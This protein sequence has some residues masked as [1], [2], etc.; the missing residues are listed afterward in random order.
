M[1]SMEKT[2][3]AEDGGPAAADGSMTKA[4]KG[5][6]GLV[7]RL[8][9]VELAGQ[10]EVFI[11]SKAAKQ[12]RENE[13]AMK[14]A[15]QAEA[16]AEEAAAKGASA[17]ALEERAARERAALVEEVAKKEDEKRSVQQQLR[18][19]R[20][21]LLE[22]RESEEKM[23]LVAVSKGRDTQRMKQEV[24]CAHA[25]VA[26]LNEELTAAYAANHS[27]LLDHVRAQLVAAQKE[28]EEAA[29]SH[30]S[31]S[32]LAAERERV[33]EQR[34]SALESELAESRDHSAAAAAKLDAKAAVEQQSEELRSKLAHATEAL[35]TMVHTKQSTMSMKEVELATQ[36]QSAALNER[37]LLKTIRQQKLAAKGLGCIYSL[38]LALLRRRLREL[39]AQADDSAKKLVKFAD[40]STADS[41]AVENERLQTELETS[42]A[43]IAPLHQK[44]VNERS[45]RRKS[46]MA[47]EAAESQIPKL[48]HE[49]DAVCAERAALREHNTFLSTSLTRLQLDVARYEKGAVG[50]AQSVAKHEAE[51]AR[52]DVEKRALQSQ[53]QALGGRLKEQ[54]RALGMLIPPRDESPPPKSTPRKESPRKVTRWGSPLGQPTYSVGGKL[55]PLVGSPTPSPRDLPLTIMAQ[56]SAAPISC[57]A[58][59]LRATAN[60]RLT[61]LALRQK[62]REAAAAAAA[63]SA[64]LAAHT[65]EPELPEPG[66]WEQPPDAARCSSPN[67][68]QRAI[69]VSPASDDELPM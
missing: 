47:L 64:A 30:E 1:T 29:A 46:M 62:A 66:P 14:R 12:K 63:A 5:G 37:G 69:N 9:L 22:L 15:A 44:L 56:A 58:T 48:K 50:N 67:D 65:R 28:A 43:E 38:R 34:C 10:A 40:S 52:R 27:E 51:M 36:L 54:E 11:A 23:T 39:S 45:S 7:R 20:A 4:K 32:R 3:A 18:N 68:L 42:R 2:A 33:L 19:M 13:E 60:A 25:E 59:G 53:V 57:E 17:K 41:M 21:E 35:E 61:S 6:G 24:D 31:E 49:L 16:K 8:S 26:R 55:P